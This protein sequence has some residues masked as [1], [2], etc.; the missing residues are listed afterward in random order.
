MSNLPTI[1]SVFFEA[2][3]DT[4][5]S[6]IIPLFNNS[7]EDD[8]KIG[9][10]VD[11]LPILPVRNMVM[12]PG[13][14]VPVT[15][16]RQKAIKLIKK[17]NKG[18]K[19]VGVVT[20]SNNATEDPQFED[21]YK[22]GTIV[23]ILKMITLPDG[24]T[25][26]IIQGKKRFEVE[27]YLKNDP[28]I[29]AKV[30]VLEDK[31]PAR[32]NK[33]VKALM[34]SLRQS[35]LKILK[36]NPEIPREAQVAIDNIDSNVFLIQFLASNVNAEI[37]DKQTLLEQNDLL[38][39][40]SSLLGLMNKD[41]QFLEIKRDIHSKVHTDLDKEQRN[42]YLRQQIKVLQEELGMESTDQEVDN[43]R[44]RGDA[45][46]WNEIIAKHFNKELN[47]V[48]RLNPQSAEFP[49]Q[50][51]YVEFL[52]DL[53]WNEYTKDNF[54]LERAKKILNADHFGLEKVKERIVEYLAVLKLKADMKAP[55]L[56]LYGP[57]GVGK[58]SLGKSIAKSLGR[59]YVRMALGGV[60]DEAEMR[61][62]RKTYIG[63]MAGKIIQ[64]MK[65]AGSSNP[66]FVLD[67]IDK[68]G[69]SHRGDPASALLEIL[70]P[71]QN[72]AFTDNYLEVEYDLS[73][74]L[75]V[76]TANSLD[77]I[78]PALLDRMEILEVN[79]YTVEEKVEIAKKYLVPKQRKEHGLETND[80][81]I[82]QDGLMK[83]VDDYTRESG[84]RSL[85]RQI[86]KLMRKIAVKKATATPYTKTIKA[87]EVVNLLGAEL[88]ERETYDNLDI[89]GIV[90]GLAWTS[91][92]GVILSIE[93]NLTR[94]KGK[95]TLSGQLGDV[96][97]ESASAAFTCLKSKADE[98][99]IDYRLFDQY[100]L[101]VHLPAGA[102][103]KDGP[104]AGITMFTSFASVYT[105]RKVREN[106]A[107][108]GEITLT[109][110]VLPVGGIKEK[111]LAAKR[112]GVTDI[113]M[114]YK[115]EK[116]VLEIEA[117]YIKGLTIHYV[118]QVD[119][120]IKIALLPE[121]VKQELKFTL[122]EE[123]P[124]TV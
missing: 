59:K 40:A 48:L 49:L 86:A 99:G 112:V 15:V 111:I 64:G 1:N 120:V 76:A 27:E 78:H 90:T 31:F 108:T 35:A 36:L 51:N 106:L 56:L 18:N 97:K 107:M 23:T 80:F 37:K 43:L 50:M 79:G 33:E 39:C 114:C 14:I 24:N 5:A 53:P 102:T 9:K 77:T 46:P 30:K 72:H 101:H 113:I 13:V 118:R 109:G 115:N 61:G 82:T 89:A 25:T 3:E 65:K 17:V 7:V 55:I 81:S 29:T 96:M 70:D 68:L 57:P 45:K 32:P 19:L 98:L 26:I 63:A 105:Q 34:D 62:H 41:I 92:G 8:A 87:K 58:T 44:V 66:V 116:D 84:V 60:H 42:Y 91:V 74:V 85:D 94:G 104:S 47:K 117:E 75:F 54:D 93:S 71:E 119:E 110:K 22:V 16:T 10:S 103:P 4:E 38:E 28:Y 67:E 122:T 11:E 2:D 73:K 123:K 83:L 95:I 12:F 6:E 52:L 121:K 88:Y 100:D 124:V 21:L 69:G 20:L